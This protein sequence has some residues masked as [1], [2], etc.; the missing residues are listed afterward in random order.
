M[1]QRLHFVASQRVAPWFAQWMQRMSGMSGGLAPA[2]R[3]PVA[4]PALG[5]ERPA[6]G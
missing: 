5:R 3:V 6:R 2:D 4:W 1:W